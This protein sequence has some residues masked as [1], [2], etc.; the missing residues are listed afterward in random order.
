[1]NDYCVRE[2]FRGVE[3]KVMGFLLF[4]R[5]YLHLHV[6]SLVEAKKEFLL[7]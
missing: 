3:R 7:L 4:E 1:M 5:F 6:Q 2:P